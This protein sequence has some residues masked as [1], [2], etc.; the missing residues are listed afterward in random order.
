MKTH[1]ARP[2]YDVHPGVT[3]MRKWADALPEK[4]G[5]SLDEWAD[6][7]RRATPD[8]KARIALLKNDYGLGGMTAGQ[9][10]AY[11]ADRQTWDGDPEVYLKQAEK[12]VEA[13]FAGPKAGLRPLF[14]AVVAAARKLGADVKVCPC[15][16]I[17]PF[18]R[19]RVIAQARPASKSRLELAFA[20]E[21]VPF[22]DRLVLNPRAKGN[23]RLRHLVGLTSPADLDAEVKGWLKAAYAAD[24]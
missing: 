9:I 19:N 8:H 16:T 13:L 18:Y 22:S 15:Q 20:F 4:T 6:L 3:V 10:A 2:Q 7:A 12:Y 24:A 17:I 23:D 11:A 21:D 14:D 5:R 1:A